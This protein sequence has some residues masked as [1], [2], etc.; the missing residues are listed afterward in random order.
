MLELSSR[1]KASAAFSPSFAPGQL[2]SFLSVSSSVGSARSAG[3]FVDLPDSFDDPKA[4]T[5]VVLDPEPRWDSSGRALWVGPDTT[6]LPRLFYR[7]SPSLG[8]S[9]GRPTKAGHEKAA[10]PGLRPL[11]VHRS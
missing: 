11:P 5:S 1:A 4:M 6:L 2:S 8:T 7:V 3:D 9:T 10:C